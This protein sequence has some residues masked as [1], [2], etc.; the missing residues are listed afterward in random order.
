MSQKQN[1]PRQQPPWMK[2]FLMKYQG[3]VSFI[4]GFVFITLYLGGLLS[5]LSSPKSIMGEK[6]GLSIFLPHKCLF[7]LFTVGFHGLICVL[8]IYAALGLWLY[9]RWIDKH[10][11]NTEDDDRGFKIDNSGTFGTSSLSAKSSHSIGQMESYLASSVKQVQ[12]GKT[13]S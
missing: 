10:R 2:K 13:L 4:I 8:L 5:Q 7:A 3:K 1:K 11:F 9:T 12:E 6:L